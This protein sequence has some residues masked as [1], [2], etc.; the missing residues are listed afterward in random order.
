MN[1]D[2]PWKIGAL[3]GGLAFLRIL[4]ALWRTAPS[5]TFMIELLDSG[6]IAFALVF[7]LIR[8]FVVQAFFIPSRSMVPALMDGDRILV[9]RF[10]YRLNLPQRGDIIVF[11]APDQ[12]LRGGAKKDF[13]KR[14]IGLPGDA[15]EIKRNVGVFINGELLQDAP[16]VGPPD[17][18]WPLDAMGEPAGR[19]YIVPNNAY[20]VL[21]DNR[22]DSHDSRR[23][24]EVIDARTVPRPELDSWRVLGKAMVIFWPP[25]RIGLVGDNGQLHLP[26][27]PRLADRGWRQTASAD[28]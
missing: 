8:P 23:W 10:I 6:L 14:L 1:L 5:R 22:D 18:D 12:A 15:I 13:V 26:P 11:D 9:N 2:Q 17:E 16:D 7:L 3:I 21:G 27:D 25:S 4:W 28:L 19:P 20:F 24:S